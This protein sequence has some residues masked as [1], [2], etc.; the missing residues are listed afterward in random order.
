MMIIAIIVVVILEKGERGEDGGREGEGEE[1]M[2]GQRNGQ[3]SRYIVRQIYH[4]Q[5]K[6]TGI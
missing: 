5:I 4:C 6:V 2:T 3:M 1:M